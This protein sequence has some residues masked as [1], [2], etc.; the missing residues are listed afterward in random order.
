MVLDTLARRA[1][2]GGEQ[3]EQSCGVTRRATVAALGRCALQ[4][5]EPAPG[6]RAGEELHA[7]RVLIACTG[8]RA[9]ERAERIDPVLDPEWV[10]LG[11]G[12]AKLATCHKAAT[13]KWRRRRDRLGARARP[14]RLDCPLDKAGRH[15]TR[16]P[17]RDGEPGAV[18]P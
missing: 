15:D 8:E 1:V 12:E 5:H 11:Y 14:G 13:G 2:P 10:A 17:D 9:E 7:G 4:R 18:G 6:D 16:H 3:I